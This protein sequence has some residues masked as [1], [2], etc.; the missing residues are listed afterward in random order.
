MINSSGVTQPSLL[1]SNV[2]KNSCKTESAVL[3]PALTS[4]CLLASYLA[5]I[6]LSST[7]TEKLG[8]LIY[9][10]YNIKE[11]NIGEESYKNFLECARN[12]P[13]LIIHGN[14]I[15]LNLKVFPNLLNQQNSVWLNLGIL[16]KNIIDSPINIVLTTEPEKITET[17]QISSNT[18]SSS[19][20]SQMNLDEELTKLTETLDNYINKTSPNKSIDQND[21]LNKIKELEENIIKMKKKYLKYKLKYSKNNN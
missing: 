1:P 15:N 18:Q 16:Y 17:M 3:L 21:L 20:L 19:Q 6:S 8:K 9:L 13:K 4:G 7:D 2:S 10:L 14:R 11:Q 5:T 12:N